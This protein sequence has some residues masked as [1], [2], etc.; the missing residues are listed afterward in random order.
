[1]RN[2]CW[3]LA[4][5]LSFDL[6]DY[7]NKSNEGFILVLDLSNKDKLELFSEL[8]GV[9]NIGIIMNVDNAE[10]LSDN[11]SISH[12][13]DIY[14]FSHPDIGSAKYWSDY[15]A[16][17]KVAEYTYSSNN[18][19]TNKYPLL[20]FNIGSFFGETTEGTSTSYRMVDK[21]VFEINE[22]REL[23]DTEFIYYNHTERKPIKYTLR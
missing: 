1:V 4:K 6:H 20:P 10:Y 2:K 12:F 13:N 16:T 22:I 21:P 14:I 17:H 8:I 18:N 15:F 23:S 3:Y 7:L 11:F 5:M 19:R 9:Q